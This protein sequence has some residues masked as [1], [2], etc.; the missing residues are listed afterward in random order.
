M[1]AKIQKVENDSPDD[2]PFVITYENKFLEAVCQ[3]YK[4]FRINIRGCGTGNLRRRA[5]GASHGIAVG[6]RTESAGLE[7]AST[8]MVKYRSEAMKR[9]LALNSGRKKYRW[10]YDL[11][12]QQQQSYG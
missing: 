5:S 9:F 12:E 10:I 2:L 8:S 7:M 3:E 1:T 6:I 4:R 11:F